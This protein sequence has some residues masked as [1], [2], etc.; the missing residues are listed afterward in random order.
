MFD[1]GCFKNVPYTLARC[2]K[3]WKMGAL[4]D[5]VQGSV[6]GSSFANK[7]IA[8]KNIPK[9]NLELD[10]CKSLLQN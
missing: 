5:F 1:L 7:I 3:N 2:Y 10:V 8:G 4:F 6:E 9:Y